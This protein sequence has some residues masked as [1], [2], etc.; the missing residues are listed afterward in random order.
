MPIEFVGRRNL[1]E[2]DATAVL[3]DTG[4]CSILA[5]TVHNDRKARTWSS[6]RMLRN[7]NED[8]PFYYGGT[9]NVQT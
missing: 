3:F 6:F 2:K 1:A 8:A 7:E 4:K 5:S 9:S